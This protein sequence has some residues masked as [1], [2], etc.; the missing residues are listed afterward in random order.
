MDLSEK[1]ATLRQQTYTPSSW[2]E[3][4]QKKFPDRKIVDVDTV[5]ADDGVGLL[6]RLELPGEIAA[7]KLQADCKELSRQFFDAS[8]LSLGM[9]AFKCSF[10]IKGEN[11][12]REGVLGG[13]LINRGDLT[14]RK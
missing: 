6:L 1:V 3:F 10:V 14:P 5:F 2:L 4:W 13:I 8:D 12:K 9:R 7:E 11:P